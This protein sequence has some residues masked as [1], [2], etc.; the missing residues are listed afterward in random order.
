MQTHEFLQLA[1]ALPEVLI[2]LS[3]AG[4]LL[5]ANKAAARFLK[6]EKNKLVIIVA[7][8]GKG[9]DPTSVKVPDLTESIKA[10]KKGGLGI[11]LMKTL[12][13]KVD[14]QI[15]PGLKNQVKMVKYLT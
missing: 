10:G 8:K 7:D 3:N 4:Q 1:D 6:V 11:C 12:M 5:A 15:K 13:D 2:L 9:F 14:F